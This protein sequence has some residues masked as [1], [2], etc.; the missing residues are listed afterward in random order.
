M[1]NSFTSYTQGGLIPVIPSAI[2]SDGIAVWIP[3][4]AMTQMTLAE[5]YAFPPVGST[6]LRAISQTHD[7]TV[8]LRGSLV[9]DLRYT[10]KTALEL[11]ADSTKRGGSWVN[12]VL[13]VTGMTIRTE[14]QI[15]SLVFDNFSAKRHSLDLT[16]TMVYMPRPKNLIGKLVD[17]AGSIAVGA[18]GDAAGN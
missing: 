18:L 7:D 15:Q 17:A 14:M 1:G 8:T 3:I 12:G 4:Y 13:L 11:L 5:S 16:M 9:G 10:W 6:G 2:V